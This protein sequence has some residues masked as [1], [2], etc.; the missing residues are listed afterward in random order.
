MSFILFDLVLEF[1]IFG[2][3]ALVVDFELDELQVLGPDNFGIV[4]E[5][6]IFGFELGEFGIFSFESG[7]FGFE[8]G[9]FG[10]ELDEFEIVFSVH[11]F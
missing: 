6:G 5:F 3:A 7:I 10:L 8:L 1:G 11:F 9:S 4:L 2:P